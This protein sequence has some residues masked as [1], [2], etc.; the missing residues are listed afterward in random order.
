MILSYYACTSSKYCREFNKKQCAL[1]VY[2]TTFTNSWSKLLRPDQGDPAPD[3]FMPRDD[4]AFILITGKDEPLRPE[5]TTRLSVIHVLE[6][7][8]NDGGDKEAQDDQELATLFGAAEV[9]RNYPP[10][11]E[12]AFDG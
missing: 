5:V 6:A 2:G 12:A 7:E 4:F 1:L 10:M 11:V 8:S 9:R 3:L